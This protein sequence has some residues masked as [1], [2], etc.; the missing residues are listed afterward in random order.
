MKK[1]VFSI[2]FVLA[3]L[4]SLLPGTPAQAAEGEP[5]AGSRTVSF[6]MESSDV[7][8]FYNGGLSSLSLKLRMQAPS[9]LEF[10][11]TSENRVI[12]LTLSVP[13][14]SF[15]DYQN[16][17]DVMVGS[18]AG[19][20]YVPGEEMV[21][22]EDFLPKQLL[23]FLHDGYE[24]AEKLG[25]WIQLMD[26]RLVLN[27]QEYS[28]GDEKLSIGE[29][30]EQNVFQSVEVE[31]WQA[32]SGDFVRQMK[33]SVSYYSADEPWWAEIRERCERLGEIV[34]ENYSG[35]SITVELQAKT[36][37]K[38]AQM[39][40]QC[41]GGAVRYKQWLSVEGDVVNLRWAEQFLIPV[42]GAYYIP[43]DYSY[44]LPENAQNVRIL[45]SGPEVEEGKVTGYG[46]LLIHVSYQIPYTPGMEIPDEDEPSADLVGGVDVSVHTDASNSF[47]RISRTI[48]LT[49]PVREA[50]GFHEAL[51]AYLS[52]RMIKGTTLEIYD[53]N[54]TRYYVLS[55]S[56]WFWKDIEE[57][58][59]PFLQSE[60][61]CS[62]SW[63]PMGESKFQETY[64]QILP[65][66]PAVDS[67]EMEYQFPE[68]SKTYDYEQEIIIKYRTV[69]PFKTT[70]EV[71]VIVVVVLVA[72][73]IIVKCVRNAKR[74][75]A[76]N[77]Q[78]EEAAQPPAQR[79]CAAC[80][81]ALEP[82]EMFC[83]ACGHPQT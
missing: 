68:G 76:A 58:S 19:I 7:E 6:T 69:N 74:K 64:G 62:D 45:S 14:T 44:T 4:L 29:E 2:L 82:E 11:I 33:L 77:T 80:G 34:D 72:V 56:S 43:L 40:A 23:Y 32:E 42:Q 50:Q 47:K 24:D 27:G 15:E 54:G 37:E 73:I 12:T 53:E 49:A 83:P 36:H 8:N 48:T 10:D 21:L 39:T 78:S 70:L 59:A 16:K 9:W 57:F 35:S 38:L 31:T 17:M 61:E 26:N 75:Q 60:I 22:A 52:E 13:F 71:L 5:F 46:D 55:F 3:L 18:L 25:K 65:G 79:C 81:T 30:P 28:F 20:R 63:I 67:F 51:K 41:A 66:L 1:S